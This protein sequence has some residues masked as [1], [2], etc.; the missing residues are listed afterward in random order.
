MKERWNRA[1]ESTFLPL[2]DTCRLVRHNAERRLW[3]NQAIERLPLRLDFVTGGT[4][5]KFETTNTL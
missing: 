2:Q 1:A 3:E 4:F 5:F